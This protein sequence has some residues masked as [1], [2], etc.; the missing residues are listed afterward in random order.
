[1]SKIE[2]RTIDCYHGVER[3]DGINPMHDDGMRIKRVSQLFWI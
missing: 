2:K 3:L 1:M